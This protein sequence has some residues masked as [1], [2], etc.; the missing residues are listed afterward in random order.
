MITLSHGI[1]DEATLSRYVIKDLERLSGIKA[2][3]I[4]IWEQRYGILK[5]A[6]TD[7]NIRYYDNQDL[8]KLLNVV[9]LLKNGLRI[10]QV[11]KL[12]DEGVRNEVRKLLDGDPGWAANSDLLVHSLVVAM[13]E[14]DEER[15]DKAFSNAV[16]RFGFMDAILNVIYPFLEH[17]GLMW[18]VDDA[19]PA[20]EHFVSNLV[21]QKMIVA[22]DGQMPPPEKSQSFVLFLPEGELHEIGLLLAYYVLKVHKR[23][24]YYLGQ[25]VPLEDVASIGELTNA[26]HFLT[27]FISTRPVEEIEEILRQLNKRFPKSKL[28]LAGHVASM[29]DASLPKSTVYL[30]SVQDLIRF[31]G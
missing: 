23:K 9:M 18:G 11:G 29:S 19:N 4:R 14:L 17:V 16:L 1:N 24:V 27:F 12:G 13:I 21:R 20:Q 10:S 25:N 31:L 5:P 22:I 15:F 7:T 28:L 2:H 6:R 3:T 8:K 26:G 30:H